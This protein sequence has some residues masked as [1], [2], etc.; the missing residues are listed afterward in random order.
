[1]G[2][3][4]NVSAPSFEQIQQRAYELFLARGGTHGCDWA[5]WFTA[6]QEL[7]ATSAAAP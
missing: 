3:A 4:T 6:E 7:T 1:M 2:S 5:D